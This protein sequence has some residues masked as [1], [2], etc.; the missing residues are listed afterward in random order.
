MFLCCQTLWAQDELRAGFGV[1]PILPTEVL[2]GGI[3]SDEQAGITYSVEPRASYSFGMWVQGLWNNRWGLQSGLLYTRRS[4]RFS[5]AD[6]EYQHDSVFRF[7]GYE[8]P[9]QALIRVPVTRESEVNLA[10]GP[11]LNFFPSHVGVETDSAS[12]YIFRQ[13]VVIPGLKVNTGFQWATPSG[14][15]YLGAGYHR[16]FMQMGESFIFYGTQKDQVRLEVPLD[17]H[18]FFFELRYY[19]PG[20]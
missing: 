5:I 6:G 18:Y 15:F 12:V 17:G 2:G 3:L 16:M 10:L 8:L 20:G 4:Y 19:F 13:M 1:S 11:V 14:G 9:I 7:I